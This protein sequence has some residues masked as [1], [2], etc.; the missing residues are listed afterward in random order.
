[1]L[2]TQTRLRLENIAERIKKGE[3]VTFEEMT[4]AQKWCDHNRIAARIINQARRVSIQG[5]PQ[6]GSMDEFLNDLDIGDPDPSNHLIGPQDP[7][8]LANWFIQDKPEDWRNRD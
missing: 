8:D 7:I 6:K 5:E 2:S 1:M 4:W 3:E